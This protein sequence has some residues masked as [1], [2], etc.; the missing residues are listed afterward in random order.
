MGESGC[1]GYAPCALSTRRSEYP[2]LN[3]THLIIK[4][5]PACLAVN[6]HLLKDG[7]VLKTVKTIEGRQ[8]RKFKLIDVQEYDPIRNTYEDIGQFWADSVTGSLYKTDTGQCLTSYQI[9]MIV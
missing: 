3:M 1:C 5:E 7:A 4:G 9:R 6:F 2:T 8:Q